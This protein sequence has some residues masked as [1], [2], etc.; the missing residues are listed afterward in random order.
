M[1]VWL[2]SWK[3]KY[4]IYTNNKTTLV[5]RLTCNVSLSAMALLEKAAWKAVG[6]NK[7]MTAK[8]NMHALIWV[9]VLL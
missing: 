1:Y 7:L 9:T 8:L 6:S 3:S 5:P 2:L 4:R